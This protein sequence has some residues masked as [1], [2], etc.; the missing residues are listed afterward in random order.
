MKQALPNLPLSPF[1]PKLPKRQEESRTEGRA[2]VC[3]AGPVGYLPV[4]L[5]AV[6]YLSERDAAGRWRTWSETIPGSSAPK[7]QVPKAIPTSDFFLWGPRQLLLSEGPYENANISRMLSLSAN[8]FL[9]SH[10]TFVISKHLGLNYLTT[11]QVCVGKRPRFVPGRGRWRV[12]I[13]LGNAK[14]EE[15]L[16]RR[17]QR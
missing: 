17:D 2:G 1:F 7:F 15:R 5:G 6:R 10:S 3:L 9:I 11:F 4:H 16:V 13:G 12:E 14:W 8:T